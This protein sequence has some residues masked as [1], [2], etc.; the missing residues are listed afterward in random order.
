MLLKEPLKMTGRESNTGGG[1]V[2][3]EAT[4]P[5]INVILKDIKQVYEVNYV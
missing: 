2:R 3:N 1:K 4:V 5:R